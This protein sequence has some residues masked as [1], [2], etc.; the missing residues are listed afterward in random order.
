MAPLVRTAEVADSG[1]IASSHVRSWQ[2]G[3]AGVIS[4]SFLRSLDLELPQRTTRWQTLIIGAEAEGRFVL[5][6]EVDGEVAGWISGGPYR[7][8]GPDETPL[9]EVYGCYVDP[10]HWR[11]GVGS[12]LM[13][14]A[15][16]HLARAGDPE[17]ALWVLEE[18]PRARGFYERHGWFADGARKRFGVGGGHYPEIRYRRPLP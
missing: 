18:N 16:K 9:G 4:S 10:S 17:A 15:L 6:G 8:A 11:E 2:I 13:T 14:A 1:A 3:Y 12:A 5:V 7:G